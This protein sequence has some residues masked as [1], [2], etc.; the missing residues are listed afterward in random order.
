MTRLQVW[1]AGLS[2]DELDNYRKGNCTD[3]KWSRAAKREAKKRGKCGA[4][5]R[6]GFVCHRVPGHK[7]EWHETE[8]GSGGFT[9]WDYDMRNHPNNFAP[10]ANY[11]KALRKFRLER[12]LSQRKFAPMTGLHSSYIAHIEAGSKV[13]SLESLEAICKGLGIKLSVFMARAETS[14]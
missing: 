13:P 8:L 5:S 1:A 11:G 4:L 7:K 10:M 9:L 14:K 6:E 2:P 3:G 12:K